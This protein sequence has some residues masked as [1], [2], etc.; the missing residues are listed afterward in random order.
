MHI[1]LITYISNNNTSV[2]NQPV[3]QL[4]SF[5]QHGSYAKQSNTETNEKKQKSDKPMNITTQAYERYKLQFLSIYNMVR[6]LENTA[7]KSHSGIVH[8]S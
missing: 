3:C 7:L 6:I 1:S 5:R 2:I 8:D 4:F